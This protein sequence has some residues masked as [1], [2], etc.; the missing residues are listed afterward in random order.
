M[1]SLNLYL[2]R[3]GDSKT[4]PKQK[5]LRRTAEF[6]CRRRSGMEHMILPI[7][8]ST[9]LPGT[10]VAGQCSPEGYEYEEQNNTDS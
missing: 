7:I 9:Q 5:R 2:Y 1:Y 4:T 8:I 6:K 3:A 10:A